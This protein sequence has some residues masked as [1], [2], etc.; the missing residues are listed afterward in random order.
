[1][2]AMKYLNERGMFPESVHA[3][4][5]REG[6]WDTLT[7]DGKLLE[8]RIKGIDQRIE[9][10][11]QL[12]DKLQPRAIGRIQVRWTQQHGVLRPRVTRLCRMKG[13]GKWFALTIADTNL[14]RYLMK[15]NEFKINYEM[16]RTVVSLLAHMLKLRSEH[17]LTMANVSRT[18]KGKLRFN[19]FDDVDA[20]LD[21][22]TREAAA[23]PKP[24]D[25]WS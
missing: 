24:R 20:A 17:L 5:G 4:S 14:H 18:I 3:E 6:Y 13:S 16:T 2:D 10:L 21:E 25:Y 15:T 11:A 19:P 22:M 23:A 12:L 9:V 8:S 7:E 1:M